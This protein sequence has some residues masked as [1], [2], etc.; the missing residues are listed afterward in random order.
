MSRLLAFLAVIGFTACGGSSKAASSTGPGNPH[1]TWDVR[2]A[3]AA[4]CLAY[5][6]AAADD[7]APA[8]VACPDGMTPESS[9]RVVQWQAD[10]ECVV[11]LP[12]GNHPVECPK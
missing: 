6:A 12:D 3:G 2:S 9:V 4:G 1:A 8:M 11:E 5:A 7:A 10:G